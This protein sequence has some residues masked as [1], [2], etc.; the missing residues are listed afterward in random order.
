MPPVVPS[1]TP[2]AELRNCAATEGF[3]LV[4]VLIAMVILAVGLLGLEALGIRAI[5]SVE[6]ASQDTRA[7]SVATAYLEDALQRIPRGDV[8]RS[9]TDQE[10]PNG[11]R[12]TRQVT[13]SNDPRISHRVTV[14]VSAK[15]GALPVRPYTLRGHVFAPSITELSAAGTCATP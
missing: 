5:R 8:P 11:D 4:E 7:T 10:L 3:T 9:C 12:L 2:R 14:T 15:S 6:R 1:R 13:I